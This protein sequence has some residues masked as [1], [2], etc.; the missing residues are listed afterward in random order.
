MREI[1]LHPKS[2][3]M[4]KEALGRYTLVTYPIEKINGRCIIHMYPIAD[5]IKENGELVGY[6]D[7]LFFDAHVYDVVNSLCFVKERS[8]AILIDDISMTAKYFKDMSTMLVIDGGVNI[9][10][11]SAIWVRSQN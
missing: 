7:A 5:T 10:Y 6:Q 11:G 2:Q 1:E 4:I 8:D 9:T 3:K